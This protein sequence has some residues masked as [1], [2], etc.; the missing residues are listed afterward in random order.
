MLSSDQRRAI[1]KQLMDH[2]GMFKQAEFA[3]KLGIS[4]QNVNS[5][6]SKGTYN[7]E[8]IAV[9]FP[10]ISGDWLLTGEEPMLKKD[11]APKVAT[12]PTQPQTTDNGTMRRAIEAI[13]A[14]QKMTAKAQEQADKILSIMQSLAAS[15]KRLQ[16]G[17]E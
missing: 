11:R 14:E 10:E 9:T 12:V 1:L 13:A 4:V 7:V 8:L 2:Y 5:W 15:L 3:R 16:K 6:L 17:S